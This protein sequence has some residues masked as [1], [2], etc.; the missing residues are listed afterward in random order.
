[1]YINTKQPLILHT[2]DWKGS[3]NWLLISEAIAFL[4][5]RC[6][7]GVALHEVETGSDEEGVML[8]TATL[9][10]EEAA[11]AYAEQCDGEHETDWIWLRR[12][13]AELPADFAFGPGIPAAD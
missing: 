6:G 11:S 9:T 10:E 4:N 7:A 1:M 13:V 5:T 3:P 12:G 2:W 8:G